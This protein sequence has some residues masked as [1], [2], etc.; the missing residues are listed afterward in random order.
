[1]NIGSLMFRANEG[2]RRVFSFP[3]Q[4]ISVYFLGS[5]CG[6]VDAQKMPSNVDRNFDWVFDDLIEIVDVFMAKLHA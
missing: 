3:S 5:R 2:R 6:E 1:M 4:L